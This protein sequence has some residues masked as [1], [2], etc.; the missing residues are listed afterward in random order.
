MTKP[1]PPDVVRYPNGRGRAF[2]PGNQVSKGHGRPPKNLQTFDDAFFEEFFKD[3]DA[4]KMTAAGTVMVR[5]SR[6]RLFMEQ[7]LEYGIKGKVSD[8]K[9]VIEFF[10]GA[11]ARRAKMQEQSKT[12]MAGG[13]GAFN[14][15]EAQ[16]RL[17]QGMKDKV[18]AAVA[19]EAERE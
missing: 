15:S 7:L 18:T 13:A 12:T 19:E 9:L 4:K 2:Q 16:E 6:Y 5:E 10:V 17:L 14:W 1:L 3:V 8:R 11:E